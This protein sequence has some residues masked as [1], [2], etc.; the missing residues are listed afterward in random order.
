MSYQF[1][2]KLKGK[3]MVRW[4]N[5]PETTPYI[6]PFISSFY[7]ADVPDPTY[8]NVAIPADANAD[9]YT[10]S[11]GLQYVVNDQ[12]TTEGFWEYTNN[13]PDFPRGLLNASFR[14]AN[15]RIDGLLFDRITNLLYGQAALGAVPPYEFFHIVRERVIY[16]PQE[17]LKFTFHAAQNGYKY[18]AAIDDNVNHQ[19]LSISYDYS[20]K[21]SFFFDYTHSQ[22]YNLSRLI[23]TNYTE[24][25][26]EGHHNIYASMDYRINASTVFRAEY[27]VFGLGLDAPLVSPYSVTSFSLPTLDTEHLFRVSLT[28]D[29]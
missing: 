1:T 2:P 16:S 17:N 28:G 23:D 21:L 20:K 29:F 24:Q 25:T 14:D 27:G 3:A 22:M 7:L 4:H 13:I 26:Y 15:D 6:E 11:G 12:W 5:L 19:G 18:A 9:R 8:Q 10:Y